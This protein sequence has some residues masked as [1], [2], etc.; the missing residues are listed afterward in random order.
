M[1]PKIPG[2]EKGWTHG[3][4]QYFIAILDIF[5]VVG[6]AVTQKHPGIILKKLAGKLNFVKEIA[7]LE[8]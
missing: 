1:E 8:L 5:I 2:N 4:H 7:S 3:M 6:S